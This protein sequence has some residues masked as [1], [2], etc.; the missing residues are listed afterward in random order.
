MAAESTFTLSLNTLQCIAES[1]SGGSDPYL[2]PAVVWINTTTGN[3]GE[4]GIA[5]SNAHNVLKKGMKPGDSITIET[6]VGVITATLPDVLANF[7]LILTVGMF[8]S[9]VTATSTPSEANSSI[10]AFRST[11]A[12]PATKC[13]CRPTPSIGTPSRLSAATR[14]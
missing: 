11:G 8:H 10:T 5:A 14:S 1:K 2:W 12:L 4:A 9:S 7:D 6:T 13:D 3:V